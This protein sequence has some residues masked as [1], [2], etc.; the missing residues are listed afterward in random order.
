MRCQRSGARRVGV[1]VENFASA[2][3]GIKICNSGS[4]GTALIQEDERDVVRLFD[5]A[6][7]TQHVLRDQALIFM[8]VQSHHFRKR[9]FQESW[10]GN[11]Y[12]LPLYRNTRSIRNLSRIDLA[13]QSWVDG[14]VPVLARHNDECNVVET[15]GFHFVDN[16]SE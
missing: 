10:S 3:V 11:K 14:C 9:R 4:N 13:E 5:F 12:R 1:D 7:A 16:G 6:L 15:F 2:S 8:S